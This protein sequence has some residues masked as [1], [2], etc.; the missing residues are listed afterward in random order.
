MPILWGSGGSYL[1]SLCNSSHLL[2]MGTLAGIMVVT[3]V[4]VFYALHKRGTGVMLTVIAVAAA[5]S[6]YGFAEGA[7]PVGAIEAVWAMVV[8][9]KWWALRQPFA[10][11]SSN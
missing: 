4:L 1:D 10:R 11:P 7:W 8:A 6:I 3:A 9:R 2:A 5:G